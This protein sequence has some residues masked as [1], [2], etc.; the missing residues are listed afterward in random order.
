MGPVSILGFIHQVSAEPAAEDS[1]L[2]SGIQLPGPSPTL[3]THKPAATATGTEGG[4]GELD[5]LG[6]SGPRWPVSGQID[7]TVV[8]GWNFTNI[9]AEAMLN[10]HP[11]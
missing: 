6:C 10:P 11:L 9:D 4:R 8:L 5:C 1:L 2:I 3:G 7:R